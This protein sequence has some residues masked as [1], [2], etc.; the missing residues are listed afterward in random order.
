MTDRMIETC[1]RYSSIDNNLFS[2]TSGRYLFNESLRRQERHV[3]FAVESFKELA[4]QGVESG[5]HGKVTKMAKFAEGGF[6][7]VFLLT[8]EDGFE[9]IAKIPYKIALPRY[10]ATASEAAT[11]V[12]LRSKGVPVP[13]IYSYSATADNPAGVEYIIMEKAQGV[14]IETKWHSMTKRERFT[15]ASSFVGIEE[16]YFNLPFNSIGSIYFKHD[17]TPDEQLPLYADSRETDSTS[18]KFC[19]GPIADYMFSYGKKAGLDIHRGP[20]MSTP[21]FKKPN[22]PKLMI[23]QG[24]SP[25]N[26]SSLLQRR[27]LSRL[28]DMGS[29]W[30]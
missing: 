23:N 3:P 5:H 19:I 21:L 11:L 17:L 1:R 27:R 6:N 7:R 4:A 13:E 15:L 8:M 2:Y 24:K 29:H 12:L 28:I 30:N 10:Y 25:K 18:E 9:A 20:C 26:I 22:V 14:G 16:K